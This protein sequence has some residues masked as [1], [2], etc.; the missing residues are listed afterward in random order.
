MGFD[1]I[2]APTYP[3]GS[4]IHNNSG[5]YLVVAGLPG[6]DLNSCLENLHRL[7]RRYDQVVFVDGRH[8]FYGCGSGMTPTLS[9][10]KVRRII[11][12][13]KPENAFYLNLEGSFVYEKRMFVGSSGWYNFELPDLLRHDVILNWKHENGDANNIFRYQVE[14][15]IEEWERDL[16]WLQGQLFIL[17]E[18]AKGF[19]NVIVTHSVPH[20]AFLSQLTRFDYNGYFEELQDYLGDDDTWLFGCTPEVIDSSNRGVRFR[21]NP[22]R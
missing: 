22:L 21:S 9:M 10:S 20:S 2:S 5:E 8:P 13:E 3:T 14:S 19:S 16:S 15:V 6:R 11:L 17:K 12:E 4:L 1:L 7:S 18:A